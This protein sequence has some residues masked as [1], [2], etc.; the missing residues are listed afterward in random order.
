MKVKDLIKII[1]TISTVMILIFG[2]SLATVLKK[3]KGIV[4]APEQIKILN[5]NDSIQ[6][7]EIHDLQHSQEFTW[8]LLRLMTDNN[9]STVLRK[10]TDQSG[11]KH[12][13]DI[14]ETAEG[15][16]LAFV[17][18]YFVVFQIRRDTV[19]HRQFILVHDYETGETEKYFIE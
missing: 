19:D 5:N 3:A 9:D 18:D 11:V 13:V 16:Q 1:G 4:H 7:R 15:V 2:L 14:R 8:D 12:D 10:V 17:F 6:E